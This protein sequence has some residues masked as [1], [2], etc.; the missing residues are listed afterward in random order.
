MNR[1]KNIKG[2]GTIKG[3]SETKTATTNSS[4]KM[5]PNNRKLKDRGF[6]KSSSMFI[7]NNIGVGCTYLAK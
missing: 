4:A 1:P 6:V 3:T 5:L 7:G 2:I